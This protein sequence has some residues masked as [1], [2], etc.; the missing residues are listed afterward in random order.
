MPTSTKTFRITT[1]ESLGLAIRHYRREAGLT[2]AELAELTGLQ[3]T[4]LTELEG[5]RQTE[6]VRRLL[7]I[8]NRLGVRVVLEAS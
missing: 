7:R 2:Q 5:G 1:P 3:R 4:Y 6:Q 8:L